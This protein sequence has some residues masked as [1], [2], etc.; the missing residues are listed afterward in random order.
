M[1]TQTPAQR[2]SYPGRDRLNETSARARRAFAAV[3]KEGRRH[4]PKLLPQLE[5]LVQ[6]AAETMGRIAADAEALEQSS[7]RHQR[8]LKRLADKNRALLRKAQRR[9][10]TR[11]TGILER[12]DAHL[13]E[14]LVPD[15]DDS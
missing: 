6:E 3:F 13:S 15:G 5:A 7:V 4:D 1:T 11:A 2:P 14:Q 8:E 10:S 9:G 12:L